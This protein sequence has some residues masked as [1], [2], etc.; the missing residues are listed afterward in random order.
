MSFLFI[1][2]VLLVIP[3]LTPS[4]G[5]G[6]GGAM[7]E[8]PHPTSVSKSHQS[9]SAVLIRFDPFCCSVKAGNIRTYSLDPGSIGQ[10]AQ[11]LQ[12]CT[13]H[14]GTPWCD[15]QTSYSLLLRRKVDAADDATETLRVNLVDFKLLLNFKQIRQAFQETGFS[16]QFQ[17]VCSKER[18]RSC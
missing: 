16:Q 2:H 12:A 6:G 4:K 15:R 9:R 13:V 17:N 7:N 8:L 14:G 3:G 1:P 18:K 11:A 5:I 10:F